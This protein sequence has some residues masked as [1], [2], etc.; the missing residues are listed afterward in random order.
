[1]YGTVTA[2]NNPS[3]KAIGF[4]TV[5]L[6]CALTARAQM[7]V[8]DKISMRLSGNL[9]YGYSGSFGNAD[10][11]SNHGQ[12]VSGNAALSGYYFHPNFLS[13]ELHPYYERS[14]SSADFTNVSRGT[15]VGGSV[16]IFG[17]SHFP[18]SVGFG[19]DKSSETQSGIAGIPSV[20]GDSSGKNLSLTWN[21]L[22]PKWPQLW[23]SYYINNTSG[24]I[25]GTTVDSHS[26]NKNLNLSS[27]YDIKGFNLRA[28]LARYS[29][30]FDSPDY[31]TG[32]S[33]NASGAG[34]NYGA[35]MQH[36]LP[37]SGGM[38]VSWSRSNYNSLGSDYTSS[39]YAAGAGISPWRRFTLNE[40][41]SYTT[42]LAAA[43]SQQ[44]LSGNT[45]LLLHF[46]SDSN[47]F[48]ANTNA[49]YAVG[50][51]LTVGGYMNQ[52]IQHLS[53][54]EYSDTQYGGTVSYNRATRLFGFLFFSVGI[55]DTASKFGNNGAG[56][57]SN[58]GMSKRLGHWDT[59]AD[60]SYSQN[61]QTLLSIATT[62][63]YTYGG[64]LRRK[65][66]QYTHWSAT[67]RGSHSGL[68][69]NAGSGS[70]AETYNTNLS[71]KRYTFSA[72]YASSDGTAVYNNQGGLTATP[73]GSVFG[74]QI[75]VFNARS[76]GGSIS[77]QMFRRI[78]ISGAYTNVYSRT[79]N[80]DKDTLASGN[81]YNTRMEYRLRKFSIIGGYNRTLQDL[82]MLTGGPRIVNSYYLSLSRWFNVF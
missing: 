40:N 27:S 65:L 80:G 38:S 26:A 23:T 17:G 56:L 49:N 66:N 13:F 52:R 44:V 1:M 62:S 68:V 4:L 77:A 69:Q 8:G 72:N 43:F 16:S 30:A 46:G 15:G 71:W 48:F 78:Q 67:F 32:S 42:N 14:A 39:S 24:S 81:H 31:L 7:E 41:V 12:G 22:V 21:A 55:V 76:Y 74:D 25:L 47:S 63:S 60:F 28:N 34:T 57:M 70:Q 20:F 3:I 2:R 53:G 54:I 19:L 9:G 64:S 10:F 5:V 59:S 37:M 58:V 29:N 11:Q 36:R 51:G 79:I 82:S 50:K 45:P 73:L 35:S 33:I 75:I 6:M 18:G 61:V